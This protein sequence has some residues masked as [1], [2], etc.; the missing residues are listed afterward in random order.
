M[1]YEDIK[2]FTQRCE[3]HPA[4]QNGMVSYQ[5][6]Q[7]RLSEEIDELR[8]YIEAL[9]KQE[10]GEPVGTVGEL[11]D[12][13]VIWMRELDRDLLVYT[14]PQQRKPP[15]WYAQWIRNNYQNHPNIA[16]LCDEMTKAAHGIKE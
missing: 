8:A 1:K 15:E 6:L 10:Q 12:E 5:M 9:A 2:D 14:T 16:T 3:E 7:E 11:F 13:G 4:H